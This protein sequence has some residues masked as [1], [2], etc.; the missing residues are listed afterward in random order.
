MSKATWLRGYDYVTSVL[1]NKLG[2]TDT[3]ISAELNSVKTVYEIAK[4]KGATQETFQAD[5]LAEKFKAIEAA[6]T[7]GTMTKEDAATL[8]ENIKTNLSSCTGNF[9]EGNN[10]SNGTDNV[11]RTS[12]A[13]GN[14]GRIMGSKN[15]FSK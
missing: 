5:L 12:N 4:E 9:G 6:V 1:K 11:R 13:H 15:G 2:L 14:G 3:Q 8:N 10:H 7:N